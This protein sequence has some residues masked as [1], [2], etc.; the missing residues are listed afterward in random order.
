M[1]PYL[2]LPPVDDPNQPDL[3]YDSPVGAVDFESLDSTG[4]GRIFLGVY[5]SLEAFEAGGIEPRAG[6]A[7]PRP[8]GTPPPADLAG[9]SRQRFA[10]LRSARSSASCWSSSSV[11]TPA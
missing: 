2:T 6:W 11:E 9:G 1:V 7:R 3:T 5:A 4:R 10:R 8:R